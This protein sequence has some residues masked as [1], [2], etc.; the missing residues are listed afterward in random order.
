M[1]VEPWLC[2][3]GTGGHA[4]EGYHTERRYQSTERPAEPRFVRFLGEAGEEEGD[5]EFAGPGGEEVDEVCYVDGLVR[6]G[7]S[8]C[9]DDPGA[10]SVCNGR[11]KYPRIISDDPFNRQ[12]RSTR[13]DGGTTYLCSTDRL[14][15]SQLGFCSTKA[16]ADCI[17]G[18]GCLD[19]GKES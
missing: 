18:D 2:S 12:I 15:S 16:F 13:F 8:A 19:N 6:D 9:V 5:G 4:D 1:V 11:L 10:L 7:R 14:I 17:D 3:V